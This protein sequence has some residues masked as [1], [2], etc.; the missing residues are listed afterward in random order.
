MKNAIP[1]EIQQHFVDVSTALATP[2]N[3]LSGGW[4]TVSKDGKQSFN[5]GLTWGATTETLSHFPQQYRALCVSYLEKARAAC[6]ELPEL[7]P[8]I[9]LMNFYTPD[10][11]GIYWH[12]D[13]STADRFAVERGI[14]VVS[15]SLGCSCDF[16]WK[17]EPTDP[18]NN[19][20]LNS[21]DVLIF[22]GPMRSILHSVPKVYSGTMPKGLKM[23]PGRINL[24]FRQ[25]CIN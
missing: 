17:M 12:R 3:G 24:T 23:A 4:Y 21:G 14:P 20:V 18:E 6:S 7:D 16:A 22:G 2:T 10:N 15:F 25:Q 19:V 1:L 8:N 9:V 11:P 13:N 5:T